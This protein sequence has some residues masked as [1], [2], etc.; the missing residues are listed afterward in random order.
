MQ[1]DY[2][3][4]KDFW[5]SVL[6]VDEEETQK[7][8]EELDVER[9]WAML[10]PSPKL[11]AAVESF[12]DRNKVLDYGCGT[13]WAVL[14]AANY[15]CR[16]V[17]GV[18]VSEN[19][20][21]GT[22]FLARVFKVSDRV[23]VQ[24]ISDEWLSEEPAGKYDAIICSN[25]IDVLPPEVSEQILANLHRVAS[26]G[27]SVVIGM[28]AYAVPVNNP[29]NKIEIK[30][31]NHLYVDGILRMVSRTDEEWSEILQKYFEIEKVEHFAWPG[32]KEERRRIFYCTVNSAGM[33]Q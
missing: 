24:H 23:K 17:L 14:A 6:V 27:A 21:K 13:G 10:A 3:K 22:E 2:E 11:L 16:D 9:D 18:D 29:A 30:N 25:V 19:A 4:L 33:N 31:E 12:K 28:N 5:N 7:E 15:G 26:F 32:E 20:A 8:L 1:N